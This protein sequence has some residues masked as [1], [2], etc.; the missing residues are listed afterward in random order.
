MITY[1][2]RAAQH[3]YQAVDDSEVIGKITYRDHG[4]VR[5][6]DHTETDPALQGRGIAGNLTRFALDDARTSG[7]SVDPVCPYIATW[8]DRHPEYSDVRA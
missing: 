5:V 2:H 4:R 1:R 6:M 8:L 7:L 3:E